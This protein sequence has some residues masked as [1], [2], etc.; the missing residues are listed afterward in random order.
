VRVS[1]NCLSPFT[2]PSFPAAT[3]KLVVPGG[4]AE[5]GDFLKHGAFLDHDKNNPR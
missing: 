4:F 5:H 3:S 1:S 2:E